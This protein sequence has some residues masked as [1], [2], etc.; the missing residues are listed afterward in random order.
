MGSPD[1][2]SISEIG[3]TLI[4][5]AVATAVGF[6][7]GL[8]RE[9]NTKVRKLGEHE[10]GT[11]EKQFAGLRTYT[12]IALVGFLASMVAQDMGPWFFAAAFIGFMAL[13]VSSYF[14]SSSRGSIGGTSEVTAIIIFLLGALAFHGH[15][16]L[17]VVTA[18]LVLVLLS[19]KLPL[20]RF[21]QT[22]TEQEI[23]AIVQ[24]AI[25]SV[26]VLP[27]LPNEGYGPY[28]IWNPKEIWTMVILIAGISLVG[29]LLA[30]AM[31][32][33]GTLWAGLMGGL[34]SSTAVALSFARKARDEKGSLTF[35]AVGII[36]A[37]AIM[38]PR[39]LLEVLVLNPALAQ[40]MWLFLALIT[41]GA[42]VVA[43]IM[44][45][46]QKN[47]EQTEPVLSNPLNFRMALQFAL[48]YAFIRWLVAFT[49]ERFGDS[50]TYVAGLIS[51]TTDVDA[52]TLSMARV[53]QDPAM[54]EQAIITILLAALSNTLVKF[55][56]VLTVG[57]KE[58]GKTV[59]PGF[60]VMFA[61]IAG[62]IAWVALG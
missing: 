4:R 25:I 20:H 3:P 18:V 12:F 42:L 19:F 14:K 1:V 29:Y 6:L 5:L 40:R 11:F 13:V 33:K 26:L 8:E 10:D 2:W 45:R 58:L 55:V 51:G 9:F 24:F 16:L 39:V 37:S 46:K 61:G 49:N 48:L 38:F 44:V 56:I 31:G 17:V 21:V 34:V 52:I 41:C 54:V 35:L 50:G 23:R 30:K 59:A 15:L 62:C 57:G 36:A 7:I 47:G 32:S 27:F 28:E 53:A 43:F 22:L 60:A